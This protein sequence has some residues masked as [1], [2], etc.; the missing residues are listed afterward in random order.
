MMRIDYSAADQ[1]LSQVDGDSPLDDVWE[2]PA[3]DIARSHAGLLGR[4]LSPE[5]KR[6]SDQSIAFDHEHLKANQDRIS[7]LMG[8]IRTN[9]REWID[10]IERQLL[11]I[12]PEADL[13]DVTVFLAIGYEFGIG[14][15][16]G[17]YVNLNE[18]LFLDHP[19]QLLY[20]AIHESSHVLYDRVHEF[21]DS[22]G[23][24]LFDSPEGRQSFFETLF[25]TEA[26]ATYTPLNLRTS[27]GNVG[28]IDHP[29][30]RDYQVVF[31]DR[32]LH[33]H[34]ASYDSFRESLRSGECSRETVL[35]R[36]FD[37]RLPYRVGCAMLKE[38]EEKLGV[39]ELRTAFHMP[40]EE[41]I[42]TYDSRLEMYRSPIE[43]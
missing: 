26:F 35:D 31:D 17:A 11:R 36:T 37:A 19:R 34:V 25:H 16:N 14:L 23:P 38:I 43:G 41:F 22:I 30:C 10:Q 24:H 4:D 28:D 2:N 20:T 8:S 5:D 6:A 7:Q 18:P 29:M 39:E 32:E 1:I 3:Y 9:E 21:S 13:S 42:E 12:T 33:Q 27:D 15:Q 40:P